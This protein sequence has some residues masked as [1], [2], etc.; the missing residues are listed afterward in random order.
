MK[1]KLNWIR[2]GCAIL[3]LCLCITVIIVSYML[4]H[5]KSAK[6]IERYLASDTDTVTVYDE[7][8]QAQ[9]EPMIRGS[10]VII[11]NKQLEHENEIYYQI[12][13]TKTYVALK[14]LVDSIDKIVLEQTRFV[15]TPVTLYKETSSSKILSA[16]KKGEEVKIT[17]Y[18]M[19]N[20]YG[21]V[22]KYEVEYQ[23]KKGYVYGKYLV[24]SKEEATK[25]YDQNGTYQ[26]HL[27]REDTQGGGAGGNLDYYPVQKANFEKN[28]MPKE[29]R[30]FYLNNG[31][32]VIKNIDRY[33]ELAKN[34]NINA[35]VVD[36]KDNTTPG[37]AS[38]VMKKYS[39]TNYEHAFHSL[40]EYKSA[41]QKLKVAGFY[42]IGRITVFKDSYYAK[43]HPEDT[44]LDTTTGKPYNH[45]GSN[46]PTPYSRKV[47][48]YNVE[49]AKEAVTEMGFNEIQFDYTRFPDRTYQLETKGVMDM[50]NTYNEEKAQAIQGFLFYATDEIHSVGAYVSVDVFGES[51][52]RYVT[53]YGQYFPAMSNIVDVISGMP[54]PDHFSKYEYNFEKPVWTVPYDLLKYWGS[55]FVMK[56]QQ[57][58]PSPAITRTWIQAYD[59]YKSPSVTYDSNKVKEEIQGLK[60][61]GLTGGYMTWNSSSSLSKYQAI[62]PA[63]Q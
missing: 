23:N 19:V 9:K 3:F 36:I 16:I 29:V 27:S 59:T 20:E 32:D 43:D 25:H 53:G 56:R 61:G 47:W 58:I 10:K 45:D 54:Y 13:N 49:L 46:W 34:S 51:A 22:N 12:K 48:E 11:Q 55:E 44:I 1:R 57:E 37:Y 33:I 26:I 28:Q 63:F 2:I 24:A 38:L 31:R 21:Q 30:A 35:F 50:R 5:K 41:I 42:V 17:G 18:D 8:F 39:K 52:H 14:N 6:E 7:T 15:R 4:L 40:K 60:D 62:A